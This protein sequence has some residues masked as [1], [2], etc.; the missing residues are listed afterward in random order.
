VRFSVPCIKKDFRCNT[1]SSLHPLCK[2]HKLTQDNFLNVDVKD[3]SVRLLPFA[4]NIS[5]SHLTAFLEFRLKPIKA[6][7][8]KNG[9]NMFCRYSPQNIGD[10]AMWK[11]RPTKSYT[12]S[13]AK[14][15]ALN[16]GRKF[17]ST[18]ISPA[19]AVTQ[20]LKICIGEVIHLQRHGP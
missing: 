16:C 12:N 7:I 14:N 13:K 6:N 3:I 17:E 11:H 2:T 1:P 20:A 5:T 18:L 8:C 15:R 10:M 9:T 19:C 4:G